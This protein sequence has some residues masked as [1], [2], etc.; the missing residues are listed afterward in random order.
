MLVIVAF[1]ALSLIE[2]RWYWPRLRRRIAAGEAGAR[3]R[4]YRNIVIAEWIGV[5]A[6]AVGEWRAYAVLA[7]TAG[8]C[9]EILCRGFMLWYFAA[10]GGPVVAVVLSSFVFG[11]GHLY[12]DLRHVWV[13]AILGVV[14]ALIALASQSLLPVIVIHA[15]VDLISGDLGYRV[16]ARNQGGA[17]SVPATT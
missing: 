8:I 7:L 1:V 5:A 13:T 16:Y 3:V 11:L 17:P 9:E 10:W 6:V 2:W 12:V 4:A 14:F 15:A